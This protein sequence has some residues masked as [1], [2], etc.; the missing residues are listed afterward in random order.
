MGKIKK[1]LKSAFPHGGKQEISEKRLSLIRE[2][3]KSAKN[4]FPSRGK[5]KIREKQI[6]LTGENQKTAKNDF[7]SR[8][9]RKTPK[10]RQNFRS[11][12][13]FLTLHCSLFCKSKA[14][15]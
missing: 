4:R 11:Y 12:V 1:Q 9:N 14:D 8:G 6:S 7:P 13:Y 3:K 5:S 2:N 10:V 15:L